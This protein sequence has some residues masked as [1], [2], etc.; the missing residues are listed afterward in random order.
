MCRFIAYL[1]K[2][3][4]L[5][6]TLVFEA[7]NSLVKQSHSY[8]EGVSSVHAD[9]FGVSWYDFNIDTTP[10]VFKSAQPAWND[11]N[12]QNLAKKIKSTCFL[13]HVRA[14]TIGAVNQHNCHP[15]LYEEYSF[16]HNGTIRHFENLKRKIFDLLEDELLFN[17]KG[18]TDSEYLFYLILHFHN[19]DKNLAESV[20]KAIHWIENAQ[21]DFNDEEFSRINVVITNGK[22]LVA[23]R[24][25]SKDHNSLS[26]NY[27]LTEDSSGIT[28]ITL[29]SE[30]LSNSDPSW[31]EVPINNY[32]YI[33]STQ[34]E[35]RIN[36]IY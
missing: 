22:E 34:M 20:I 24:F 4:I 1:G 21:L 16:V 2:K 35:V 28:S 29:S 31:K 6:D 33:N 17:I 15:F 18:T 9:G 8:K 19:E 36:N 3:A 32:L 27:A 11:L 12:L 7:E 10:A 25:V 26:L 13:A 5:L 30:A 23:T 14:S